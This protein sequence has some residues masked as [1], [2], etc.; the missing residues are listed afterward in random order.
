MFQFLKGIEREL[1]V[2]GEYFFIVSDCQGNFHDY[3]YSKK[4]QPD[5]FLLFD[6]YGFQLR[7]HLQ[8]VLSFLIKNIK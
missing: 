7:K 8:K 1:G 4:Y 6:E 3:I 5:C 2:W